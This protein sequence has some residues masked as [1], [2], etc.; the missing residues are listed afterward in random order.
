MVNAVNPLVT[1]FN[2]N[3]DNSVDLQVRVVGFTPGN[4]AEISGYIAQG[5]GAFVPFS[6]IQQVPNPVNGASTVTVHVAPTGLDPSAE[7]MVI[8]RVAQVQLWPTV[9]KIGQAAQG[10]KQTWVARSYGTGQQSYGTGQ[11]GS[12]ALASP[13]PPE[14][15]TGPDPSI[16]L[17]D[18]Q[19][20]HKYKITI[21]V[22]P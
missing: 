10:F 22:V 8:T 3:Q 9:L 4:W 7:A 11:L 2:V 20:G 16:S 21:K 1:A 15:V 19:P 17:K 18:M 5:S 6:D 12:Q 14:P 13:A